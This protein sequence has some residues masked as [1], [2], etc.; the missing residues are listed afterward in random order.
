MEEIKN[1]HKASRMLM[2]LDPF[3]EDTEEELDYYETTAKTLIQKYGWRA[4]FKEWSNILF[5]ECPTDQDV[6]WFA[7]NF[8]CYYDE[9]P[10]PNP[11]SFVAY[12]YYRVDVS[13]NQ[14]AF[15][16]FDSLAISILPREG[17]L[18]LVEEPCYAAETDPRIIAEI[19]KWKAKEIK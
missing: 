18:D 7:H 5:N 4:I 16:I 3:N 14:D 11:L 1:L 12:F 9:L 15:D 8:Y 10:V 13:K 19:E 2:K 17:L 6:I